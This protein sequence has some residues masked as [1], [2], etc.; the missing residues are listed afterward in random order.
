MPA[1]CGKLCLQHELNMDTYGLSQAANEALLAS[2][3]QASHSC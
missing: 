2:G 3:C 1:N